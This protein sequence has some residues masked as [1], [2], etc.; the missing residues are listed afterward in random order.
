MGPER[1]SPAGL[2]DLA[3]RHQRMWILYTTFLP[4]VE[5]QEPMDQWVQAQKDTFVRVPIKAP[6]ALAY[7]YLAPIDAEANLKDRIAVLEELVHG[8]AGKHGRW[9]RHSILADAYQSLG[10]LHASRGNSTLAAEY[11][12]KAEE[13]RAAAPPPW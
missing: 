7:A 13:T 3:L 1:L 6:S 11:W 12:Y 2:D 9:V 4:A 5:L 8:P 10:D